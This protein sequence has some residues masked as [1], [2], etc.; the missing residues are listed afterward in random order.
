MADTFDQWLKIRL[1]QTGAYNNTWGAVLNADALA[2]LADGI[3]GRSDI[4]LTGVTYS[5]PALSNGTDSDSRAAVL[6]FVGSPSGT[7]TVTVPGSVTNKLYAIDNQCGQSVILTYVGSTTTTTVAT[8]VR[9]FA[10]CDGTDV[11]PF[12]GGITNADTLAGIAAANYARRDVANTFLKVNAYPWITVTEAPSTV[13]DASLGNHQR[14][15]LTA[16]RIIDAPTNPVDGQMLVLQLRQDAVGGRSITAW[17]SVFLFENGQEPQIASTGNAGDLFLMFYDAGLAKWIVGH[18][19]S[20]SSPAS[21]G[22]NLTISGNQCDVSLAALLGTVPS[23]SVVNVTI[24]QGA[25][26]QAL[27]VGSYAL[28][29]ANVLPVGSV[30]NLTNLGYMIGRGG[31]G[32]SGAYAAG[33]GLTAS[34][35]NG[36][37]GGP[38]LRAPGAGITL[39]ITN[40][41][42]HIWGGGGGAG[43]G[44]AAATNG[45]DRFAKGGGGGGG[46]G[47]GSGG[48][49]NY[50]NNGNEYGSPNKAGD[51]LDGSTGVSGIGG[52]AGAGA[53]RGSADGAA[54]G[55]G[56]TYGVA[57]A[58]GALF[59]SGFHRA[60]FGTGGAAGKSVELNG[61]TAN[62]IDGS[63]SPNVLGAVA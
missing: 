25:V 16:D 53:Q 36:H 24:A 38:A 42:G 26:L 23:A 33:D 50:Q 43:G 8:G 49:G 20:I 2:A 58:N 39:N 14:L 19:G 5:L 17:N 10:L 31:D 37:A 35:G 22:Y 21:A 27:S 34:G 51:G 55:L 29:L 61:G 63:G 62:F 32:G 40:A 46:A 47:G 30:I 7:V 9:A 59:G 18:F 4:T 56:G 28:D 60:D 1:I 13:I 52:T 3:A 57:G 41:A 12:G 11:Y 6:R 15:T 48:K 44:S 54:G 45:V